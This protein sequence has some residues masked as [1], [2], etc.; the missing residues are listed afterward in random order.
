MPAL[1]AAGD[2]PK[3]SAS[4]TGN[5]SLAGQSGQA[6]DHSTQRW[7]PATQTLRLYSDSH[8]LLRYGAQPSSYPIIITRL[9]LLKRQILYEVAYK[10]RPF[11]YFLSNI[12]IKLRM[13]AF[14]QMCGHRTIQ[15]SH[16]ERRTLVGITSTMV[17]VIMN[18]GG[19][20][21]V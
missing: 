10:M 2:T 1:G 11:W 16:M 19:G 9:A 6:K 5:A 15:P 13:E 4:G 7:R 8:P 17:T 14:G 3:D 21:P 18:Q 12:F 20:H